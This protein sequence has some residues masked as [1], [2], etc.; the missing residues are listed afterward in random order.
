MSFSA[1]FPDGVSKLPSFQRVSLFCC[2]DG[3]CD[4]WIG[5][6]WRRRQQEMCLKL[7]VITFNRINKV[8]RGTHRASIRRIWYHGMN[9]ALWEISWYVI[10]LGHLFHLIMISQPFTNDKRSLWLLLAL[11]AYSSGHEFLASYFF[12]SVS[13]FCIM[14]SFFYPTYTFFHSYRSFPSV[15]I[16]LWR[17][18]TVY[19]FICMI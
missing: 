1:I 9:M 2:C 8:K 13:S 4:I 11:F 5:E 12:S 3:R 19:P 18:G 6:K 15:V 10:K 17:W 7:I 16:F 14:W